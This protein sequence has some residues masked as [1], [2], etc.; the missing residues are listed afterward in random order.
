V[1][2]GEGIHKEVIFEVRYIGQAIVLYW[3]K[4]QGDYSLVKMF[5]SKADNLSL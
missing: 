4:D 2:H 5:A 1:L 3:L